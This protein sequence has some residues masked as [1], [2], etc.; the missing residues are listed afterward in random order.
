MVPIEGGPPT[1]IVKEFASGVSVSLDSRSLM[2]ST[3]DEQN[4]AVL[5]TCDLPSCT[6]RRTFSR[7]EGGL[8]R[9]GPDGTSIA[10]RDAATQAN[11]WLQPLDGTAARQLT[12]FAADRT[13]NDYAWSRDGKR[14]AVTRQS[15]GNDIVLFKGLRPAR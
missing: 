9:W 4:R 15:I 14:L 8:F 7:P 3:Q 13:I 11:L 10:Y 12:R 1:E 2:Y 6:N 5:V